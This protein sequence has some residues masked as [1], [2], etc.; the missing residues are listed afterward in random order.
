M[1]SIKRK[2]INC[3]SAFKIPVPAPTHNEAMKPRREIFDFVFQFSP[4]G[5]SIS[6]HPLHKERDMRHISDAAIWRS[7]C[8]NPIIK[9]V[10]EERLFFNV[11]SIDT[12][13][14][15]SGQMSFNGIAWC[16]HRPTPDTMSSGFWQS[17]R[18]C[19]LIFRSLPATFLDRGSTWCRLCKV[20]G[21]ESL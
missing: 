13:R 4:F 18:R 21:C 17:T 20:L 5:D 12:T 11:G 1:R 3:L 2:L 19:S 7:S 15:S 16:R 8:S 10:Y 6:V 9:N 14:R